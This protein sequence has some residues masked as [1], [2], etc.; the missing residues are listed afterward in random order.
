MFDSKK[1][2]SRKKWK[3]KIG[4]GSGKRHTQPCPKCNGLMKQQMNGTYQCRNSN[5]REITFGKIQN[6][7]QG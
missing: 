6:V 4:K 5:C 3:H 1:R 7:Q 2:E